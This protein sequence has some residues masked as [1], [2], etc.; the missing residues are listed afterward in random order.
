MGF[1]TDCLNS[2][3]E[4]VSAWVIADITSQTWASALP[5]NSGHIELRHSDVC[6]VPITATVQVCDR[7]LRMEMWLVLR[8]S[9]R[10]QVAGLS[11][12]HTHS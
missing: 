9:P 6:F 1:A 3:W 2:G 4:F 12:G 11:F 8:K 10:T 5:P 7:P